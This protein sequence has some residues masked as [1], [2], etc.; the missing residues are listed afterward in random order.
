MVFMKKKDEVSFYTGLWQ[1][2]LL[3]EE[4]L[5]PDR[6]IFRAHNTFLSH[7]NIDQIISFIFKSILFQGIYFTTFLS[8]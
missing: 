6:E 8:I 4:E 5:Y 3:L 1:N 7:Q 2:N